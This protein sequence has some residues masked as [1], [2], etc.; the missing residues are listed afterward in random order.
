MPA[1]IK[2]NSK[3]FYCYQLSLNFQQEHFHNEILGHRGA[4]RVARL[5]T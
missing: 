4:K 3:F 5:L 1:H 2:K